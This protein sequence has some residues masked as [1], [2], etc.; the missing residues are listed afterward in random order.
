MSDLF[1]N[2][3]SKLP[4]DGYRL[5]N[6]KQMYGML[7]GGKKRCRE[8]R[9]TNGKKSKEQTS[10]PV[11][12]TPKG[13]H[14]G[15]AGGLVAKIINQ[16]EPGGACGRAAVWGENRYGLSK[17]QKKGRRILGF[18]RKGGPENRRG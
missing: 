14:G 11:A 12:S 17:M 18:L 1:R 2:G 13:R 3:I 5:E 9:K 10:S 7:L 8:N 15:E 6:E 16:K 4:Q